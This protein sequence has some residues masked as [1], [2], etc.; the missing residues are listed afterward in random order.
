MDL[1]IKNKNVLVTGGSHGIGLATAIQLATEG[2]NIAICSR[3]KDRLSNAKNKLSQFNTISLISSASCPNAELVKKY[4][5]IIISKAF[6]FAYTIP[7]LD[8]C[9]LQK[10]ETSLP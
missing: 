6:L 7:S 1:G 10:T 5:V 3:S 4:P 8:N 2:C 9:Q